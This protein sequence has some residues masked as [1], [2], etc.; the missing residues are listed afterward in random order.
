MTT[1]AAEWDV[2]STK[3][4]IDLCIEQIYKKERL[5]SSFTRDGWKYII[6]GFKEKTLL[7]YTKKQLKNRL[8]SLRRE[9]RTWEKL[10]LKET[11]IS[12]DYARNL[13]IAEDEWWERKIKENKDY[14]KYRYKGMKFARELQVMFKDVLALGEEFECPSLTRRVSLGDDEDDV[15]RPQMDQQ[16]DVYRPQMDRQEDSSDSEEELQD[17]DLEGMNLT[18]NTQ[19]S[20]PSGLASVGKR[21][22]GEGGNGSTKKRSPRNN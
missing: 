16:D 17:I 18:S 10:F 4:F 6:T 2:G 9:W 12:I 14:R 8:D 21:K 13:V 1:E 19:P 15:Y 5:G 3:T 22:R 20:A 7:E 11:G